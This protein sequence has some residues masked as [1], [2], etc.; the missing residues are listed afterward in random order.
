MTNLA[1]A[2]KAEIA[3]LARKEL[4]TSTDELRKA[5]AAQRTELASVKKKLAE[6]EKQVRGLSRMAASAG[7]KRSI[8][9]VQASIGDGSHLRFR[10]AGMAAN[11][12]RLGL[13]A[14]DFGMLVG[15]SGVS[16]Y[17]WEQGKTKPRRHHLAAI[18]ALRSAGKR[19]VAQRLAE[20]KAL[21]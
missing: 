12:K 7:P 16:V 8:P 4:R 11:R 6:L 20:L 17:Q 14:A 13:S 9:S 18:A 1:I 21:A 3:R 19:E 15:A 2:L 5:F 10:A